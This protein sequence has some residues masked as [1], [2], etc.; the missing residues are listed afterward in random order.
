MTE[1]LYDS[2]YGSTMVSQ[3]QAHI[4]DDFLVE[5]CH[6]IAMTQPEDDS[7]PSKLCV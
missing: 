5:C 1:L 2:D 6:L 7:S 4:D 3:I